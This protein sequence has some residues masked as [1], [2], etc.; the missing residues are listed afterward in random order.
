MSKQ[1]EFRNP[2]PYAVQL[3][4]PDRRIFP[5]RG[6]ATVILSDWFL[7]YS[8][9]DL[10]VIRTISEG[11]RP[12]PPPRSIQINV[13][14]PRYATQPPPRITQ[15]V[16]I[17]RPKA[18][19]TVRPGPA[20]ARSAQ[21]RR[22]PVVGHHIG[23]DPMARYRQAL[24]SVYYPISGDVGVGIM[25]FNR[26]PCIKRLLESIRQNTDLTRTTVFVSDESTDQ[27]VK[28][29]LRQ[30]QDIVLLDNTERLG[31]AGNS[32]R[33][34]R[35]LSR[36]KYKLLLNDDVVVLKPGWDVFYFEK[37]RQTGFHHFC[38]RQA[39]VYGARNEDGV[40]REISGSSIQTIQDKPHGSVISLDHDAFNAVGYFDEQFGTYGMEHVDWSQRIVKS[41]IQPAG[42]HDVCG[43][44]AFFKIEHTE[45]AVENRGTHV[46][47][48]RDLYKQLSQVSGRVYV[49]PSNKSSVPSVS[50]VIPCRNT[51]GRNNSI[52]T[53]INN[54]KAQRFPNI[55]II[56]SE[57]DDTRR[58]SSA[59]VIT[60]KYLFTQ[61]T[62]PNRPFVKAIAF[63][64]GVVSASH[65]YVILHDGDMLVP[66]GY[67]ASIYKL[68]QSHDA[69]HIG[70]QVL[71]LT[72]GASEEVNATQ[73]VDKG[74]QCDKVVDYFVGGSLAAKKSTYYSIG[75]F[76]DNFVGYGMEDVEF[77]NR[78]KAFGSFYDE[79]SVDMVHLWHDRSSDW[80]QCHNSNK[81]Y[82]ASIENV[83]YTER[84][85][86]LSAALKK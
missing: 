26:L 24:D 28:E 53:V 40:I 61:N 34:L 68:L 15:P 71:Y 36:F 41:G 14:A 44:E 48:A 54:I 21:G 22:G 78:L 82:M 2:H 86:V 43:S 12:A 57:Q 46:A 18:V 27:T 56:L 17:N 38:Y 23:G 45:S 75:G 62:A 79:R 31:V 74:K 8:P 42:Y 33:L 83:P 3:V 29:W 1:I 70:K 69:C 32:N 25:S 47:R 16:A 66:G 37:M 59:D 20:T 9:K 7:R 80:Q 50:Y 72:K 85:R 19:P 4:G 49:S 6:G 30:Q 10:Q 73:H 39:G 81:K 13:Q 11:E 35:C 76:D 65:D 64:K 67:T 5:I 52:L 63:N 60:C 51:L 84:W 55:E 77:F 58:L